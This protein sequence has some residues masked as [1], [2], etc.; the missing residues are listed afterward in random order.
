MSRWTLV[1]AYRECTLFEIIPA[2]QRLKS[3][4]PVRAAT[5]DGLPFRDDSGLTVNPDCA[6]GDV[7]PVD[8]VCVLVPGGNPDGIADDQDVAR[9]VRAVMDRGGVVAGIC[10]GV[11]VLGL[12]GALVGRR[13]AHNYTEEDVP[14]DVRVHTDPLWW[15][16][17]YTGDGISVDA[18]V[19]TARPERYSEFASAVAKAVS[20]RFGRRT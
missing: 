3:L 7:D 6:Y 11:A 8:C 17:T 16:T 13:V 20:H 5:P 10:A 19:I 2:A 18:G 15:N 14:A 1:L 9:I 12:A 4:F